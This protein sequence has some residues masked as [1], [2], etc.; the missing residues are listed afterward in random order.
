MDRRCH[1]SVAPES[2]W[3]HPSGGQQSKHPVDKWCQQLLQ[4]GQHGRL[5]LVLKLVQELD[6]LHQV[7]GL[8]GR[9]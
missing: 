1:L 8:Q 3:Y 6:E 9:N 5:E 2:V 7:L 4:D